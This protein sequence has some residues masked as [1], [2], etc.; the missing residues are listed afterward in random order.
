MKKKIMVMMCFLLVAMPALASLSTYERA[1]ENARF[2]RDGE[3]FNNR[4]HKEIRA[5]RR[6]E[7]EAKKAKKKVEEAQ[8]KGEGQ[9]KVKF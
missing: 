5:K 1:H 4:A 9:V 7:K 8:D 2:K 6:A 3:V